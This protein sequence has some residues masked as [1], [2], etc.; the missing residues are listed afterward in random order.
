MFQQDDAPA[1]YDTV[2]RQW[3]NDK[4][5]EKWNGF[6]GW[7]F[8]F[9]EWPPGSSDLGPCNHDGNFGNQR[10]SLSNVVPLGD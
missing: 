4:F 5:G 2:E 9:I 8:V 6:T 1:H 7:P 10:Q 3:L